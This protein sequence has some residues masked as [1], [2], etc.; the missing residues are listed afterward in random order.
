MKD[1]L[2]TLPRALQAELAEKRRVDVLINLTRKLALGLEP[3]VGNLDK[4]ADDVVASLSG[5]IYFNRW[6]NDAGVYDP[7]RE[8]VQWI[9]SFS[10]FL[11][12]LAQNTY[13]VNSKAYKTVDSRLREI[14][15]AICDIVDVDGEDWHIRCRCNNW[16]HEE[17]WWW[18]KPFN[19]NDDH[20]RQLNLGEMFESLDDLEDLADMSADEGSY[21]S[22]E[23][24]KLEGE[25]RGMV[26]LPSKQKPAA[27]A[28]SEQ[29]PS[30]APPTTHIVELSD[31]SAKKVA[32]LTGAEVKKFIKPGRGSK[33]TRFSDETKAKC[34]QIWETYK[35]KSEVKEHAQKRRIGHKDV[36]ECA[37]KKLEEIGISS[38][39][40]FHRALGAASDKKHRESHAVKKKKPQ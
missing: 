35:D 16:D 32:R 27:A 34:S 26:G 17:S 21:L 29:Q 2:T 4:I 30:A 12:G 39:D 10:Q 31:E 15:K 36:Y 33:N 25:L 1:I 24:R 7:S 22:Q 3:T 11:L 28:D 13:T 23:W 38:A 18:G 14:N 5:W 37:K 20:S 40:E 6:I 9:N 8:D 19:D